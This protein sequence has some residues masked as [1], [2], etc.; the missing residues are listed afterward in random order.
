MCSV[1]K[2]KRSTLFNKYL[3][4]NGSTERP[5]NNLHATKQTRTDVLIAPSIL[6]WGKPVASPPKPCRCG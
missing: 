3:A 6:L 5:T 2:A 4:K 1:K